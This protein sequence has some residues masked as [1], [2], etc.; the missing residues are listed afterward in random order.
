MV[1]IINE[2][3]NYEFLMS[4]LYNMKSERQNI[5]LTKSFV[6]AL[7]IIELYKTMKDQREYVLAKQLLR[8]GT[9]IGANV[10][11]ATAAISK[12]EFTAKMSI[13]SKEARK[14]KVLAEVD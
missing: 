8:S 6:F 12:K 14:T 13:S 3:L 1:T 7:Q 5:I 4:N 2:M 9:S 11:E 10:E